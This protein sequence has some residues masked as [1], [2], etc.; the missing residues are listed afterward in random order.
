M[1]PG[2]PSF[3]VTSPTS[4]LKHWSSCSH[5]LP[6]RSASFCFWLSCTLEGEKAPSFFLPRIRLSEDIFEQASIYQLHYI[7]LNPSFCLPRINTMRPRIRNNTWNALR[8]KLFLLGWSL[9]DLRFG[10]WNS[11]AMSSHH[12]SSKNNINFSSWGTIRALSFQC[13]F[14]NPNVWCW[15]AVTQ[16]MWDGSS[17]WAESGSHWLL[18]FSPARKC[19][20]FLIQAKEHC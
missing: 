13:L 10:W 20:P 3:A 2:L 17:Y 11:V 8:C 1:S 15:W 12:N 14:P 18:L 6:F 4:H 5:F 7:P 19:S 9:A 16:S